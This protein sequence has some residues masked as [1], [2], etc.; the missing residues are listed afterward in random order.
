M[1][2]TLQVGSEFFE[3][4]IQGDGNGHGTAA[5]DFASAVADKLATVFG[6]NDIQKTTANLANNVST[7]TSIPGLSFN[8]SQ[9]RQIEVA[10]LI[11]RTT[12]PLAVTTVITEEF[13]INGSYDGSDFV[14]RVQSS[15]DS[16]V[17][18]D[19]TSAGQMTYESSNLADH[20][21]TI[22]TFKANTLDT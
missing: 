7:P 16:G 12:N 3:Y 13:T 4:P 20:V 18:L 9:V 22:I 14:I 11:T 1:P 5:S 15:G 21:S 10:I 8:T 19:I 17:D 2:K 6:P